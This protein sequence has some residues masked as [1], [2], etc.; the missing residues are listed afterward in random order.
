MSAAAWIAVLAGG[1]L[2]L[3]VVVW[4]LTTSNT[5]QDEPGRAPIVDRPAGPGAESQRVDERGP[6]A[7]GPHR[8]DEHGGR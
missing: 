6:L 2:A 8:P 7:G 1:A 3:A 4:F 5:P